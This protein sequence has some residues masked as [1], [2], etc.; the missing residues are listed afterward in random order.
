MDN[1]YNMAVL[2]ILDNQIMKNVQVGDVVPYMVSVGTLT[3]PEAEH[4]FSGAT[5]R[6]KTER[7]V[8][9]IKM[10]GI[11]GYL[12]L[13]GALAA[14]AGP[15]YAKLISVIDTNIPPQPTQNNMCY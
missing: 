13:R 2:L 8:A 4:I 3:E 14:S 6:I 10:R 1:Y 11:P 5:N 12:Q 7:L 15:K 9:R